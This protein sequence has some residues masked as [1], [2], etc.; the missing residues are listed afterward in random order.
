MPIKGKSKTT[1]KRT[2][3]LFTKNRSH[4]KKELDR[5]W[6]RET[7]SLRV[8]GFEESDSSSSSLTESTSRRRWSGSF[9]ENKGKSS[10]P[11]LTI[12]SLVW[13]SMES[14]FGSRR[15]SKKEIPVLYWWSR[16]TC[17]LP[18]S[19]RTLRTQSYWSF[20]AGQ[21]G[22][23]EQLLPVH[24][25]CRMCVSS[26]CYHQFGINTWR[27]KFEHKTDSILS[28]CWSYGHKSQ[29]SW[30]DRLE[31]TT[32][33]TILAQCMEETSRRGILVDSILL[34]RK[35]WHSIRLDR[36]QSSFKKHFQLIVF[37]KLS[38]WKLEKSF[39]KKYTCHLDLRQR[40]H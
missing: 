38:D 37:H 7:F 31:C 35:D 39:T 22:A 40:S 15:R 17:L 18:S 1:K 29:G 19:S 3:W 24:L 26:S 2:C 14:M 25:P 34:L 10:E 28:A 33:C 12:Y 16:S 30:C 4:G 36:M 8:R 27:S 5:Y 13:R 11:I 32:S 23:S 6:T 20:I 9:L 21:C